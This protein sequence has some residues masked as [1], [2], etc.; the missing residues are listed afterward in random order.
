[1]P[2][3]DMLPTAHLPAPTVLVLPPLLSLCRC[4]ICFLQP[5]CQHPQCWSC[6]RCYPYAAAGY[7]SYSPSASTHSAGLAPAAIPM[8]LLDMLPTAHLPAPT[9]LV[10]PP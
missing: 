6:P 7:A 3:L 2:L 9:V 10:L 1:M 5:I 8:P 4:W